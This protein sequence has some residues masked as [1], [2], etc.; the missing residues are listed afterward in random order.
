MLAVLGRHALPVFCVGSL[1]SALGQI[2]RLSL[3]GGLGVD[4]ILISTGIAVQVALAW[5]LE[6]HK[7]ATRRPEPA[8]AV[9]SG[10]A[11]QAS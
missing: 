9:P 1:L 5:V 6:W 4:L 7:Q 10:A 2:L 11:L 8:P 3:G